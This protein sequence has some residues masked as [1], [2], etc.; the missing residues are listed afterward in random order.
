MAM[1]T[2]IEQAIKQLEAGAFQRLCNDFLSREGYHGIVALGSEAGSDK[3]TSGTP[4][5]YFCEIDGKYIF[6]E[7]TTQQTDL[8]N[9]IKGDIEK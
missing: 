2:A 6:V 5:A 9:K 7:Y 4:D 3:T 1:I 8:K